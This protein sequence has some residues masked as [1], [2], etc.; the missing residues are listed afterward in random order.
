MLN[1]RV[2][3]MYF[4]FR[5]GTPGYDKAATELMK[6]RLGPKDFGLRTGIPDALILS[7]DATKVLGR[8]TSR[9]QFYAGEFY[10]KLKKIL[11]NHGYLKLNDEERK[12]AHSAIKTSEK[13][14]DLARL[15]RNLGDFEKMRTTYSNL[16]TSFPAHRAE[17]ILGRAK[18]ARF[19]HDN[20]ARVKALKE[21]V[22]LPEVE[23]KA[24]SVRY[25][26]ELCLL[27]NQK[28]EYLRVL[29]LIADQL[30]LNKDK[31]ASPEYAYLNYL[32]GCNAF[33]AGRKSLACY[34]WHSVMTNKKAGPVRLKAFIALAAEVFPFANRDLE[35]YRGAGAM[36]IRG[37]DNERDRTK[38]VYK[39]MVLIKNA[40]QD[41]PKVLNAWLRG[42][43]LPSLKVIAAIN[44]KALITAVHQMKPYL[45]GRVDKQTMG[46][47]SLSEGAPM[48]A[49]GLKIGDVITSINGT[50]V[51]DWDG[52]I[53][54]YRVVKPMDNWR[55]EVLRN[56]KKIVVNTFIG[57]R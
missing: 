32:A 48:A 9:E 22:Q 16:Q 55:L 53:A 57:G 29:A 4:C 50:K 13:L 12:L 42:D 38:L 37:A 20:E 33:L 39:A 51:N 17:A 19:E 35:G 26:L 10:K 5:E 2:V 45:G 49:S 1:Q 54:L 23:Q 24:L 36:T 30:A 44:N 34:Y 18:A 25:A 52:F 40:I 41:K 46:V 7:P 31:S 47:K 56:G 43:S 27:E 11:T 15:Y 3:S 8:I 28:K 14:T 21:F 6:K